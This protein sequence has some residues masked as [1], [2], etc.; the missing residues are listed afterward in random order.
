MNS[1]LDELPISRSMGFDKSVA[2]DNSL[3]DEIVFSI[4]LANGASLS[5]IFDD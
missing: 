4:F 2:V 3:V 1:A 5:A